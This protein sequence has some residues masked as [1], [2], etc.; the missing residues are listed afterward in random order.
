MWYGIAVLLLA[1]FLGAS[2]NPTF[3]KLGLR[4]LPIFTYSAL[5]FLIAALVFLPIFLTSKKIAFDR[6][7]VARLTLYTLLFPLN[8]IFFGLAIQQTTVMMTQILYTMV[9]LVVGLISYFVLGEKVKRNTIAG[10]LIS[11]SGVSFLIFQS[12]QKQ[13]SLAFGTPMGNFL[14]II[15]VLCWA[16]Y[17]A[18]SKRLVHHYSPVTTS[19]FSFVFTAILTS[20][21]APFELLAKPL[22]IAQISPMVWLGLVLVGVGGSAIMYFLMQVG[23][24]KAAHYQPQ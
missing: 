19:F 16:S 3:I 21:F 22:Q 1:N 2:I 15:A 14:C 20:I 6:K 24:K 9:P 7:H 17:I 10:A 11:F 13:E 12:V 23:I 18:F 8:I 4:E 5:R